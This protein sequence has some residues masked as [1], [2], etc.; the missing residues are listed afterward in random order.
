MYREITENI[1]GVSNRSAIVFLTR[2]I[3]RYLT[4]LLGYKIS[5]F[6]FSSFISIFR[7]NLNS[8]SYS[9]Y[10]LKINMYRNRCMYLLSKENNAGHKKEK[11][12]WARFIVQKSEDQAAI[13][14][15]KDYL[16]LIH[17]YDNYNFRPYKNTHKTDNIFYIYGPNSSSGPLTEHSN[18]VIVLT[19]PV[20][21]DISIYKDSKLFLNSYYFNKMVVNNADKK[22]ELLKKYN[23]IYISCM[24][25]E[26]EKGFKRI[27]N[28]KSGYLSGPM[29]LGR[30]LHTLT[31][32]YGEIRCIIEG[33]DFYLDSKTYSSKYSSSLRMNNGVINDRG[34]CLSLVHHDAEYNFLYVKKIVSGIELLKSP[35]LSDI[36]DMNGDEYMS[37]LFNIRDFSKL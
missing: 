21:E 30:I 14:D 2:L 33:F 28:F 34:I 12:E 26:L 27:N 36:I 24:H 9:L 5:S 17:N 3:I 35:I 20:S 32:E 22:T 13:D 29:A 23:D 31:M 1:D 10:I 16:E 19:K 6:F 4:R 8:C 25:S 7:H 15:A 11:R 37:E 18:C